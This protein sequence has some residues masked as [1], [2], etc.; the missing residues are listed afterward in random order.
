V[1]VDK[2]WDEF[3]ADNDPVIAAAVELLS[4]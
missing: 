2:N 4:K 3:T 1:L